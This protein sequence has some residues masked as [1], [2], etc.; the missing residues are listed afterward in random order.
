M[1]VRLEGKIEDGKIKSKE[2]KS[3]KKDV[4]VKLQIKKKVLL[5]DANIIDNYIE[6]KYLKEFNGVDFKAIVYDT[7]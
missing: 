4:Y 1:I 5:F 2:L 7:S 3:L 6:N